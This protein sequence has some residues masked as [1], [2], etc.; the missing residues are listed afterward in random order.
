[1]YAIS[2]LTLPFACSRNAPFMVCVELIVRWMLDVSRG[3]RVMVELLERILNNQSMLLAT[4]RDL[5]Y[6]ENE[7]RGFRHKLY[8]SPK[9]AMILTC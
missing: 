2:L 4:L 6:S 1:M 5:K 3:A 9:Q 8:V 7:I